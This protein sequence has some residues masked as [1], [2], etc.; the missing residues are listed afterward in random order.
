MPQAIACSFVTTPVPER[1]L[2]TI[3]LLSIELLDV[4]EERGDRL[5]QRPA[6]RDEVVGHVDREAPDAHVG[7]RQPRA[8]AG[9]EQVVDVLAVLV[10]VPEVRQRAD[11]DEV[12][13][14]ADAVVHDPGELG[15]DRPA[16]GARGP[17][18]S[19][20]SIFSTVRHVAD[21]VDHRRARS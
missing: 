2:R 5:E 3:R 19:T 11:V 7:D 8:A 4:V 16:R 12:G 9:L 18:T 10:E 6:A 20:P 1:R 13:A 14:D 17:G 15:E 21:A